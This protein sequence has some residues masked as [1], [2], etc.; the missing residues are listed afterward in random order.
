MFSNLSSE[1]GSRP[2]EFKRF[3]PRGPI[4]LQ[5]TGDPSSEDKKI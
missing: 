1:I 5:P 2:D 4:N 3:D